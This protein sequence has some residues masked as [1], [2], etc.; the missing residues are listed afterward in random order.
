MQ[1]CDSQ[2]FISVFLLFL[3][4]LS[5]VYVVL[6]HDSGWNDRFFWRVGTN[7]GTCELSAARFVTE[8]ARKT[9]E[10]VIY[11]NSISKNSSETSGQLQNLMNVPSPK[12]T[13]L[14]QKGY[15]IKD[16][17]LHVFM[18]YKHIG[19]TASNLNNKS[20]KRGFKNGPVFTCPFVLYALFGTHLYIV[21]S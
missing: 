10:T 15:V 4:R 9:S 2:R 7:V 18:A 6:S 3:N 1:K 12:K 8:I 17:D 21:E 13:L 14:G 5:T 11:N 20:T 19:Y 16:F